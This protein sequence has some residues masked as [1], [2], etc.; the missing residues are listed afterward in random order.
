MS[1][2]NLVPVVF[3]SPGISVLPG[4]KRRFL[5]RKPAPQRRYGVC[6]ANDRSE[7]ITLQQ[8]GISNEN[9]RLATLRSISRVMETMAVATGLRPRTRKG[10]Y[11]LWPNNQP[12]GTAR[13]TMFSGLRFF[14]ISLLHHRFVSHRPRR[15]AKRF[16]PQTRPRFVQIVSLFDYNTG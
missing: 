5:W 8:S 12:Y 7:R 14:L 6:S 9:G 11:R 10:R 13:E 1:P 16:T 2:V 4:E 15:A 3:D